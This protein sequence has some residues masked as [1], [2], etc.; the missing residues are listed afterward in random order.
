M[1]RGLFV[2]L[3]YEHKEGA[4]KKERQSLVLLHHCRYGDLHAEAEG[5]YEDCLITQLGLLA[6][7]IVELFKGFL[8]FTRQIVQQL[9]M[10]PRYITQQLCH[11]GR[12]PHTAVRRNVAT[13]KLL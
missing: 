12:V 3:K 10:V 4:D 6:P 8:Q 5:V 1:P 7:T 13:P 9:F 2:L 11:L